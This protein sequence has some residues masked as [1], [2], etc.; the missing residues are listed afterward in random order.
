[1]VLKLARRPA[2]GF[3]AIGRYF[4]KLIAWPTLVAPQP[5]REAVQCE[6]HEKAIGR[7]NGERMASDWRSSR[8]PQSQAKRMRKVRSWLRI[9]F[10]FGTV[11]PSWR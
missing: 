6:E 1:M 10:V 4:D 5:I 9:W 3:G 7:A 11:F 2:E 8:T